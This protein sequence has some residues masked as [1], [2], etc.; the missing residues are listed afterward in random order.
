MAVLDAGVE[1]KALA[2]VRT[3]SRRGVIRVAYVF[4]SQTEGRADAWSD[5]D[6]AVFMEGVEGLDIRGRAGLV[7]QVMEE[8]GS[9]V[10]VH[11]FPAL[12]LLPKTEP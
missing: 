1:D 7:A 11:V 2:A 8:A 10:E 6:V 12:S 3:L 4:G 9:D 5:I